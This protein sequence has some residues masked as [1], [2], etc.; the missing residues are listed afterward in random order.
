MGLCQRVV[1]HSRMPGHWQ[2]TGSRDVCCAVFFPEGFL[3]AH[4][5]QCRFQCLRLTSLMSANLP[6]QSIFRC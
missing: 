5:L 3:T 6:M 4:F 2:G 1:G